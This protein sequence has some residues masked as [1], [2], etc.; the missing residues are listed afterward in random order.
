MPTLISIVGPTAVGKTSLSLYLAQRYHT[1]IL[2]C[3]SRQMYR[4]MDIGT[5]K[6]EREVLETVCHHFIDILDPEE[7]YNAGRFE[8]EA[9][10]LLKT[11]F[12][13]H[14]V[15]VAVGGST[16]YVDALWNGIHEMPAIDPEIRK[17]LQQERQQRGLAP[18]L[19][20]LQRVDPETYA[21]VDRNNPV[22]ILRALEV[23]RLYGRIN[24]RVDERLEAGLLEEGKKLQ[25][26]GYDPGLNAL[27]T[28]GYQELIAFL[29]GEISYDEAV[30]L[31]KRNSRRYA[32]RQLTWYRRYP[33]IQWFDLSATTE[34]EIGEWIRRNIEYRTRNDE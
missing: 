8:A 29:Q 4:Y 21:K 17:E 25:E 12:Q 3:D 15:V 19:E 26:M 32:K 30:R 14:E 7:A 33:D 9:E 34:V 16:L 5:A 10:E 13:R 24:E 22:R 1:D 11:L 27:Q 2:S 18:L 23:Y 31:I 20:E 28:I 6:P